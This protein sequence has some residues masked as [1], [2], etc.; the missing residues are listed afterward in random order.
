MNDEVKMSFGEVLK[1]AREKKNISLAQVSETLKLSLDKIQNIES[2]N[3]DV[4]PPAAFT[5]GYLRLFSRLVEVNEE[6]VVQL[7]YQSMN[8]S[9]F[10]AAPGTTSDLLPA[11]VTSESLSMRIISYSLIIIVIVLVVLWYQGNRETASTEEAG[12]TLSNDLNL[13]NTTEE[14]QNDAVESVETLPASNEPF[15]KEDAPVAALADDTNVEA[16]QPELADAE[17]SAADQSDEQ[18]QTEDVDVND[19]KNSKN[20]A[21]AKEASPVASSGHDV[22]ILT[23]NDDCW[24]EISDANDHLLYFSLLKKGE[25]SELKGQEPFKVFLGRA[26]SVAIKLNDI[27]YDVSQ[28][29]RSN[30]IARFTMSMDKIL[31]KSVSR[32][33]ITDKPENSDNN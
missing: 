13:S 18:D 9:S 28:H 4:L 33:V 8:Q 26:T 25:M 1:Q 3:V 2:A 10:D 6:E 21:L 7:Y 17:L 20:I 30:Q 12:I 16:L 24:V 15:D 23:A 32:D 19:D 11:Q 29:V 22:V 14:P 31:E 27:E 5:C